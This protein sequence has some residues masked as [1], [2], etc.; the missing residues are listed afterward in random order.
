[1][2]T[3]EDS[4]FLATCLALEESGRPQV[5]QNQP[6]NHSLSADEGGR[7][8][9][10]VCG[11]TGGATHSLPQ[12]QPSLVDASSILVEAGDDFFQ[13]VFAENEVD[14]LVDM[15]TAPHHG[16]DNLFDLFNRLPPHRQSAD[17]GA[18]P[19]SLD[20]RDPTLPAICNENLCSFFPLDPPPGRTVSDSML[21]IETDSTST[22]LRD[23]SEGSNEPSGRNDRL[24]SLNTNPQSSP[25][26]QAHR[27]GL[28][29]SDQADVSGTE[30]PPAPDNGT[31][32]HEW[33]TTYNDHKSG[34]VS[35]PQQEGEP[36]SDPKKRLMRKRTSPQSGG[37][38]SQP[39][40]PQGAA[41]YRRHSD[42]YKCSARSTPQE[43]L[44]TRGNDVNRSP[45]SDSAS[46]EAISRRCHSTGIGNVGLSENETMPVLPRPVDTESYNTVEFRSVLESFR[47]AKRR[48][49]GHLSDGVTVSP[50][51]SS[52]K[53]GGRSP[54]SLPAEL[55]MMHSVTSEVRKEMD[56]KQEQ[57][58]VNGNG[59]RTE[60]RNGLDDVASRDRLA[61]SDINKMKV[62]KDDD[63][64]VK[65]RKRMS[66]LLSEN[67]D[68][69]RELAMRPAAII[70]LPR[71]VA[72]EESDTTY[73]DADSGS[74]DVG[75][76]PEEWDVELSRELND[77]QN[78]INW[79]RETSGVR[80]ISET[81]V[82][83]LQCE[84]AR[85]QDEVT[86]QR[87]GPTEAAGGSCL[88]GGP[89]GTSP[90]GLCS[91]ERTILELR[92]EEIHFKWAAS[93]E[94][95]LASNAKWARNSE[96]ADSTALQLRELLEATR[97][98][99]R[100]AVKETSAG[101]AEIA[102]LKSQIQTNLEDQKDQA[103]NS[104]QRMVAR[105]TSTDTIHDPRDGEAEALSEKLEKEKQQVTQLRSDGDAS[106]AEIK[107]QLPQADN[108]ALKASLASCDDERVGIEG[109]MEALKHGREQVAKLRRRFEDIQGKLDAVQC[110]H[111]NV[112]ARAQAGWDEERVTLTGFI[113]QLRQEI[114]DREV[115]AIERN[116]DELEEIVEGLREELASEKAKLVIMRESNEET[117]AQRAVTAQAVEEPQAKTEWDEQR[118]LLNDTIANLRV[119]IAQS[120]HSIEELKK[121][122]DQVEPDKRIEDLKLSFETSLEQLTRLREE[123]EIHSDEMAALAVSLQEIRAQIEEQ[124]ST[125][126]EQLSSLHAEWDKQKTSMEGRIAQLIGEAEVRE[127]NIATYVEKSEYDE[128]I[129]EVRKA[130]KNERR[131]GD[132]RLEDV[133]QQESEEKEALRKMVDNLSAK[134]DQ[135][136]KTEET[137]RLSLS[138]L[139][140]KGP[141]VISTQKNDAAEIEDTV[142][143][144]RSDVTRYKAEKAQAVEDLKTASEAFLT[145]R[146]TL[147][148]TIQDLMSRL[149]GTSP[150]V[151]GDSPL[152][153]QSEA[154]AADCI[155]GSAVENI[156]AGGSPQDSNLDQ[157]MGSP[158]TGGETRASLK[159]QSVEERSALKR[160]REELLLEVA[161]VH[162]TPV[163]SAVPHSDAHRGGMPDDSSASTWHRVEDDKLAAGKVSTESESSVLMTSSMGQ[164]SCISWDRRHWGDSRR[165][166][167]ENESDVD[168][169]HVGQ[170]MA[171][172]IAAALHH[173]PP[174]AKGLFESLPNDP[175][176]LK[177]RI[178]TLEEMRNSME[179]QL[180][181]QQ[182]EG[183]STILAERLHDSNIERDDMQRK[184]TSLEK[185]REEMEQ[186]AVHAE[187]GLK[188]QSRTGGLWSTAGP[189]DSQG[190]M[191]A[192]I[193]VST[194][195]P[196]AI[197]FDFQLPFAE[198]A[199]G[200]C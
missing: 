146:I 168:G 70:P 122:Q 164:V 135:L 123:K 151:S 46:Q 13:D 192:M 32:N 87:S 101:R 138:Q 102:N 107:I 142:A 25:R 90:E 144:L 165:G 193:A 115:T 11:D 167:S 197:R 110:E 145:E 174:G 64:A 173:M 51:N 33:T 187:N 86:L 147:E 132:K 48:S 17:T 94:D 79:S 69:K 182:V 29:A 159:S 60:V 130:L 76:S 45:P 91:A 139:H 24:L 140:N 14:A 126:K 85:L 153:P 54:P 49:S 200:C 95:L 98:E 120:M 172:R 97:E 93:M 170:E 149:P 30:V 47:D 199:T 183:C 65:I 155:D 3:T 137:R 118:C 128:T 61:A 177:S 106:I 150:S 190:K 96:Q 18:A 67:R 141:G 40:S 23:N 112:L 19:G 109:L 9:N 108:E 117:S 104:Q 189:T 62:A 186:R 34:A 161:T 89:Q 133:V 59:E 181:R 116:Y 15:I 50:S 148:E 114:A 75:S 100:A 171:L 175:I 143:Q 196:L 66:Y 124:E 162:A 43:P 63:D 92:I 53:F 10:A 136:Q 20:N 78:D 111:N 37:S 26:I 55:N 99:L 74:Q 5:N 7:G 82:R 198:L 160:T 1:M 121:D 119:Q 4:D 72:E 125:H 36:S 42:S 41:H 157:T 179:E 176:E 44:R 156:S 158:T 58:G 185:A 105:S 12:A 194:G 38:D 88:A 2:S 169:D 31:P 83:A 35:G 152:T 134:N 81:R 68:L 113:D 180:H 127:E 195:Y 56:E 184:I 22:G 27:M 103:P 6:Q 80:L 57:G 166:S 131:E 73:L 28:Q 154:P 129:V 188:F 77:Y 21:S 39:N 191:V 84:L 163:P 8:R 178:C 52:S 71:P 16:V